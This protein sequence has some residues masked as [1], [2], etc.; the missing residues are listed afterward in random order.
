M[1][2]ITVTLTPELLLPE[3]ITLEKDSVF[4]Y[5]WR[6]FKDRVELKRVG[7]GYRYYGTEE[8]ERVINADEYSVFAI[9]MFIGILHHYDEDYDSYRYGIMFV[10][11]EIV[12]TCSKKS[13]RVLMAVGELLIEVKN[14]KFG[15]KERIEK[16]IHIITVEAG[17]LVS[18]C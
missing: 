17:G 4:S 8:E 2:R 1:E 5:Q 6:I 9:E 18:C 7:Q 13:L 12:G 3:D 16:L 14:N 11:N 10:S 15:N